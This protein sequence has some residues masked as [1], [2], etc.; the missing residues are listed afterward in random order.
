MKIQ[1]TQAAHC[2]VRKFTTTSLRLP[3]FMLGCILVA[4][5]LHATEVERL[6][7]YDNEFRERYNEESYVY[8]MIDEMPES[9]DDG[10]WII[11]GKQVQ[12][13]DATRIKEEYGRAGVGKHVEVEGVWKDDTIAAYK[14]EVTGSREE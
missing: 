14:I 12:A 4:T 3:A 5:P 2:L 8:G 1:L 11:K 6:E 10:I 13:T 7:H 9:R